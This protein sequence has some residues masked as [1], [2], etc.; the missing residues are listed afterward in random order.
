MPMLD[1]RKDKF[2]KR[3]I[4]IISF[5]GLSIVIGI[6]IILNT[7]IY[8]PITNAPVELVLGASDE[9]VRENI[10]VELPTIYSDT[11][12]RG[13]ENWSWDTHLDFSSY[14]SLERDNSIRVE[15]N[16]PNSGFMIHAPHFNTSPYKSIKLSVFVDN[17]KTKNDLLIEI[18]DVDGKTIGNQPLPWYTDEKILKPNVWYDLII[19]LANLNAN[20]IKIGGISIISNE[21][22]VIFLDDIRFGDENISFPKW[23]NDSYDADY[24][25]TDYFEP[26][27]LPYI[28]DFYNKPND[29]K[30]ENG[31]IENTFN[32]MRVNTATDSNYAFFKLNG[33]HFWFNYRYTIYTDWAEGDSINLLARYT[34]ENFFSCS[35]FDDG[36]NVILYQFQ[37]GKQIELGSSPN[38]LKTRKYK[39]TSTDSLGI[40]VVGDTVS[41]FSNGEVKVTHKAI[42]PM[43]LVGTVARNV[44]PL[45]NE[46]SMIINQVKVEAI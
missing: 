4:S 29:W 41:C 40:E 22:S 25:L 13:W 31:I 24:L 37:N 42:F 23:A 44:S 19:P 14:V 16:K 3:Y 6:V 46:N 17:D 1:K 5:V 35:F 45:N 43:P 18:T 15:F 26:I 8:R 27:N 9:V 7:N 20:N 11:L 33:G 12:T 30:T 2:W 32:K 28:S 36:K 39:W 34:P 38:Y 10:F 21:P